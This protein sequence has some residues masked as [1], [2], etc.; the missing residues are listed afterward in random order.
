MIK[1]KRVYEKP[2][3]SDGA[4]IL[5]DRLWSRGFTKDKERNN[6]KVLLEFTERK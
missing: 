3:K 1:I 5:V 4:R 6:A 2:D